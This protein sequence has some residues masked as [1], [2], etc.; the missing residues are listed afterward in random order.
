MQ[1]SFEPREYSPANNTTQDKIVSNESRIIQKNLQ[2]FESESS[3]HEIL[4]TSPIFEGSSR[5]YDYIY[6]LSA[7]S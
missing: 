7:P 2:A 6:S 5:A 4:Q 3:E 1:T